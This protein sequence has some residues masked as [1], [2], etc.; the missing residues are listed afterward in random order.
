MPFDYE[1]HRRE[2]VDHFLMMEK[3]DPEYARWALDQYRR[4]PSIPFPGIL[5]DVKAEKA[6]REAASMPGSSDK[7]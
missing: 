6:R 7:P 5:A 2:M 4:T 1:Q 3:L